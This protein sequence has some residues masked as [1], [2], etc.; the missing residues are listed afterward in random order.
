MQKELIITADGSHSIS[1]ADLQVTYHSIYGAIQESKH[2]FI[3]AGLKY[4]LCQPAD[5]PISILEIGFGTGLNALLSAYKAC[6]AAQFV[7]AR[8]QS[9][10][11]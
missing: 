7:C 8:K 11:T 3:E 4:V 5:G 9:T 1:I 6:L 10:S 2:V